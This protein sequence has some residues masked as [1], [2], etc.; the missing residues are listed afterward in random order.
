MNRNFEEFLNNK[1]QI[2]QVWQEMKTRE[3]R[4]L[5]ETKENLSA[6]MRANCSQQ[7]PGGIPHGHQQV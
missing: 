5:K 3:Q 7:N 4:D 2:R 6:E 1:E